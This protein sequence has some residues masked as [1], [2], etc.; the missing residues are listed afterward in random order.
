MDLV[1]GREDHEEVLAR[2]PNRLKVLEQRGRAD[3][4]Y[5][6]RRRHEAF[7]T[8]LQWA[9]RILRHLLNQDRL[10]IKRTSTVGE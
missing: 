5:S 10:L 3:D 1:E 7:G 4:T 6:L 9:I 8:E 2:D